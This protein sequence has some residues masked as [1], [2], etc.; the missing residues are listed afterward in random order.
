MTIQLSPEVVISFVAL[1][2]CLLTSA[3]TLRQR[4]NQVTRNLGWVFAG[5]SFWL[6][7]SMLEL[8]T[9]SLEWK[10]I[11]SKFQY[12]SVG[13]LPVAWL[14][15]AVEYTGLGRYFLSRWRWFYVHPILLLLLVWTNERHHLIWHAVELIESSGFVYADFTGGPLYWVNIAYIYILLAWGTSLFVRFATQSAHIYKMQATLIVA[16]VAAPW[17]GN[18]IYLSGLGPS[19][20]LDLTPISFA[21]ST[22]FLSIALT[23]YRLS[24]LI[25][26]DPFSILDSMVD[27]VVVLDKSNILVNMN[28][29]A[30]VM[31][32]I[33]RV[34]AIG[35]PIDSLLPGLPTELS[36][37]GS[38]HFQGVTFVPPR[39]H[40]ILEV[41]T[42]PLQSGAQRPD[43]RLL[44]LRDVTERER[45]AENLRRSEAKNQALLE[46]IPDQMFLLDKDGVYREFKTAWTEDLPLPPEDLLGQKIRDIY[47]ADQAEG[48]H[49]SLAAA[50]ETGEL[51]TFSYSLQ[52]DG[53]TR[54]YDCRFV[55][56]NDNDVVVTVRN[57]TQRKIAEQHMREQWAFLRSVVDTLPE[58]VLI[59]DD[60][61]RYQFANKAVADAFQLPI[62]AIL[63]KRDEDLPL[64]NPETAAY[65]RRLDQHVLQTG[66]DLSIEDDRIQN[67][68]GQER[69]YR[70]VKRRLFSPIAN[71]WQ[72]LTVAADVTERR[73]TDEQTRLQ[74]TALSAAANAIVITDSDANIEWVNPAFTQL[75]GYSLEEVV[76]KNPR[77]LN[78][79]V[80]SWEFFSDLWRTIRSGEPWHG[81][82]VNRRKNGDLYIEEMTVTPVLNEEQE[83]THFV[84]IK[85]DVTQRK[86][87]AD[88][89]VQQASDFRLQI[90]IGRV[91]HAATNV[92]QLFTGIV[93]ALLDSEEINLQPK[94]IAYRH[95][96]SNDTLTIALAQGNFSPAFLEASDHVPANVGR[97]GHALQSGRVHAIPV[98]TDPAC[99]GEAGID[100]A[101]HGHVIVPMNAGAKV[102][103]A[104]VLFT[105][106][107]V[108]LEGWD[109]RRL[110]V[111]NVIGGQIG[112]TLDRLMQAEDLRE[113]KR[114]AE[115]A[116]RAKSEFLA[117][118]S[119]EIRTPMNAVIGMTSLL[120]DTPLTSEQREFVEAVRSSGDALLTL[121]NDILDFSKIESGHMEIEAHPFSLQDCVEDVL[122]LLAPRAAEKGLELAFTSEGDVPHT[123][124]GDVTRLRQILVNLVGNGIKFT[125]KGEIVVELSCEREEERDYLLCFGIRDTGIGIPEERMDRLFRSFSQIDSS[126]T[127]RFGGT[128]LGLAISRRLAQLMGGDMWVESTPGVGSVFYFTIRATAAA[129]EKRIYSQG[130]PTLLSTKRLL[131]VDDNSTNREIFVRQSQAWGM[132]PVAVDSGPAALALLA[133]DDAFDLAILDMQMPEMDGLELAERIQGER[134]E[135]PFPLLL[136]TS[137]GQR[138]IHVHSTVKLARVMTK[139]VRRAHLFEAMLDIFGHLRQTVR[140]HVTESA[141]HPDQLARLDLNLRILL[142]EDNAV[143]QK[144]ALHTLKRLGYRADAVGD[145][146]EV[147]SSLARRV[148]DVV[149]MD[150]QM[151]TLDGLEATRRVRREFPADRQPY[152]IAMTANAMQGDQE[153]CL[154]AGMDAY[155]SKPF[156]VEDLVAALQKARLLTRPAGDE[157]ISMGIEPEM[158]MEQEIGPGQGIG[159]GRAGSASNPPLRPDASRSPKRLRRLRPVGN[160]TGSQD[161]IR[162][163]LD[164]IPP[165]DGA[166]GDGAAGKD[167]ALLDSTSERAAERAAVDPSA[168]PINWDAL[169]Q[170][171]ADLGQGSEPFLRELISSFMEDTA[172]HLEKMRDALAE[173]DH[174]LLHRTAHS[175]KSTA[176]V[177]G[178][179]ALS[180]CCAQ[181]EERSYIPEADNGQVVV[182]PP[183]AEGQ[184]KWQGDGL[185]ESLQDVADEFVRVRDALHDA[186]LLQP[187]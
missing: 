183:L 154:E 80:H 165:I 171:R 149:L 119:H 117:N 93:A 129:S 131:I 62:D 40:S 91:L 27:G 144:V 11:W 73:R 112:L 48:M 184:E 8:A 44:I 1:I 108:S 152:I 83:I 4:Q 105:A 185:E 77:I 153:Q 25:P 182:D 87:D 161:R 47:P 148:Y 114:S 56:Y 10:I 84:A 78:S 30:A 22:I 96:P 54:Y 12:V 38:E 142:A 41:R 28:T 176:K 3:A 43:G 82:L 66:E 174:N 85:Q 157:R 107:D 13:L 187:S 104:L 19:P 181:L 31:M 33:R 135:P 111:F 88:R 116:N 166:G 101:T 130:D 146:E 52:K 59:K 76:G 65:Y 172:Q 98:C 5:A 133:E 136:L 67:G 37:Q 42:V 46:A 29:R 180:L 92:D 97:L 167:V 95:E 20:F 2:L 163:P 145:G 16:G 50:L 60:E 128:G 15:L 17:G 70:S 186:G 74:T 23:Q 150:V 140:R 51:Q 68:N 24:A 94:A 90:E 34:S 168:E 6:L 137:I 100:T 122:D 115:Q 141:F 159:P 57:V 162:R 109:N 81:E 79:G 89:L 124:V 132:Q 99:I 158:G 61:G 120:L 21:F 35:Q 45:A 169:S 118:M 103:G 121:I 63:G 138:E 178:A 156:K 49:E 179:E 170:L 126:T 164:T 71:D 36:P 75:T 39:G 55:A 143:N 7:T 102:L 147:L 127:R 113:A 151:P 69:W 53:Q 173:S 139:P 134:T 32:G 123:I 86:R 125:S 155:I 106:S 26:A 18:I 72:V 160:G 14:R 110:A 64:F 175:L 177:I 9:S 58:P